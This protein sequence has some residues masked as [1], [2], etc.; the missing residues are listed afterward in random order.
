MVDLETAERRA[1]VFA[2]P[3]LGGRPY[4]TNTLFA[5]YSIY[6]PGD[7]AAVHKHTPSA[8]RFV[9]EGN[10]GFTNVDGEKVM[11][12]RGDLVLTPNGLWHDHGQ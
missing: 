4:I 7:V 9:L 2:N 6:N 1:L 8:S 5:A 12:E 11:L 3:G 10:G